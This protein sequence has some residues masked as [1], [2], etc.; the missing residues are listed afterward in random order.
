MSL[1]KCFYF[2]LG[3]GGNF[4]PA[5]PFWVHGRWN[6]N[7]TKSQ[8]LDDEDDNNDTLQIPQPKCKTS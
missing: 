8:I 2:N 4:S 3:G 7:R 5:E 1:K 6:L